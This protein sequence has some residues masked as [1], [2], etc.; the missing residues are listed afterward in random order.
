MW[1]AVQ[2]GT[3]GSTGKGSEWG[4]VDGRGSGGLA[5]VVELVVAVVGG[6]GWRGAECQQ[7]VRGV[8]GLR[9]RRSGAAVGADG[10]GNPIGAWRTAKLSGGTR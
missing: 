1:L 6:V 4:A 3:M 9:R 10:L 2:S 7:Q 5:R 8:D